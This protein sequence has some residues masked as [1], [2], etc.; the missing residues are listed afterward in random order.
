MSHSF[1]SIRDNS[2]FF[3]CTLTTDDDEACSD[4][5]RTHKVILSACS[6][7]FKNILTKESMCVHPNPLIYLKGISARELKYVLDFIYNGEVNVAQDE[8]DNFL[9]V[10][11]T[12]KI[13]GLTQSSNGS[14]VSDRPGYSAIT[15]SLSL[16]ETRKKLKALSA[17]TPSQAISTTEPEVFVKAECDPLVPT[18]TRDVEERIGSY[19]NGDGGGSNIENFEDEFEGYDGNDDLEVFDTL[20]NENVSNGS[21]ATKRLASAMS[22]SSFPGEPRNQ[23]NL[24]LHSAVT[25]SPITTKTDPGS[26]TESECG[27]IVANDA[28]DLEGHN[29][30]GSVGVGGYITNNEQKGHKGK[31]LT[32]TEKITLVNLIKTLDTEHLLRNQGIIGIKNDSETRAKRKILWGQIISAFNDICGINCGKKKLKDT[33]VRI[34]NTPRWKSHSILFEDSGTIVANGAEDLEGSVEGHDG[35][36][37]SDKN[38]RE[39]IEDEYEVD[40][41]GVVVP[42]SIT[43]SGD[44]RG[45]VGVV[46]KTTDDEQKDHTGK[47][48]TETEKLTLVNLIKTLDTERLLRNRRGIRIKKDSET[49]A[50]RRKLW[51]QIVP[52]FNEIC[53]IN[54]GKKKLQDT[55]VRIKN[56]PNSKSHSVLFDDC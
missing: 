8:L 50:K 56:L 41:N 17:M 32:E 52:A 37:D 46:G 11:E 38:Q 10:A 21:R 25:K 20:K 15:P 30:S 2:Q 47:H 36:D 4:S 12:L 6:E 7:F 26:S 40:H 39:K 48:L 29:E 55:L 16:G 44:E 5:L 24:K 31:H 13:K 28:E 42:S 34:K 53:G 18:G 27:T 43:G 51:G 35:H 22:P 19:D 3:D 49:M 14:V 33:L 54:C 9:E 45:S 23:K 1:A